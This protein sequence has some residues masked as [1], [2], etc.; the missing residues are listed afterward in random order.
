MN[1]TT[2]I[3]VSTDTRNILRELAES[4]GVPMQKVIEQAID[5]YQRQHFLYAANTAYGQLRE[6]APE[7]DAYQDE[8]GEWDAALNDGLESVL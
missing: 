1:A 7:W 8:Q 6:N 2:T 4:I 5:E 3:R